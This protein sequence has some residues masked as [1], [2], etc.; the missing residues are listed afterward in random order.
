MTIDWWTLGLQTVNAVVLVWIL[1]R[2]LFRPVSRILAER[3]A[4]AHA[5]LDEAEAARE[6]AR[7][8]RDTAQRETAAIAA[9]R[10]ARIA[11]AQDEAAQEK[12]RLLDE[13]R[14]AA[15]KARAE[16]MDDLARLRA[17]QER[18]LSVEAGAL[19]TD[20][21][22]KLL[23]RLPD[24]ARIA[25]FID[26]LAEAV[27]KL[28]E[29]TRAGIAGGGPVTLRSARALSAEEQAQIAQRLGAVLGTPPALSVETD[30]TLL[31]GLELETPHAIVRNH[32]RADLDRIRAEIA[33]HE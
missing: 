15:E 30:A 18:D 19:A 25:G 10:A 16:G 4:A 2:F 22:A 23:A 7:A 13:A 28:P 3:Q 8:A 9:E 14:A 1:A 27:A 6:E 5:A 33:D 17:T 20:I 32:F 29:T 21:A 24:E 31:A 11:R 26:G 12:R